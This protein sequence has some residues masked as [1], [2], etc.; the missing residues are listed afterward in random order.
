MKTIGISNH[1]PEMFALGL[2]FMFIL[3]IPVI[4]WFLAPTY[5]LVASYL[6]FSKNSQRIEIEN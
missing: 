4:G 2:G 6:F 5:G 1:K 3:L